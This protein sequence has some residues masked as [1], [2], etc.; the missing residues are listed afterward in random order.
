MIEEDGR[1]EEEFIEELIDTQQGLD[2]L[3]REAQTLQDVIAHN[4]KQISGDI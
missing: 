2:S 4:L 1:T 3:N